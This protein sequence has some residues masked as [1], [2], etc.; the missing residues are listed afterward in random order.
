MGSNNHLASDSKEHIEDL[1]K[2]IYSPPCLTLI[3]VS[4]LI[5]GGDPHIAE[6]SD[7]G[8]FGSS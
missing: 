3:N 8:T 7:G 2:E 6:E 5:N 1:S 4:K